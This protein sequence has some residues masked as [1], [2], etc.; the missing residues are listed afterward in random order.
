[1][2]RR[3]LQGAQGFAKKIEV[4]LLAADDAFQLGNAAKGLR[5]FAGALGGA[6]NI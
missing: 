1:V 4:N 3:S 6:K 5:Q 2:R